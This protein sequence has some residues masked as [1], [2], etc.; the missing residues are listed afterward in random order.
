[1]KLRTVGR[2]T[3]FIFGST[4]VG[5]LASLVTVPLLARY[6]GVGNYGRYTYVYAFVG[7]FEALSVFGV[8]PIFTREV[9]RHRDRAAQYLGNIVPLKLALLG[10]TLVILGAASAVF[11]ERA[12]WLFVAI[13]GS[14]VLI[15]K[16][17]N[18]NIS[19]F[20]AFERMEY[21]FIVNSV[22]RLTALAGVVLAVRL[23]WGL[24][25]VFGA[26]AAG[27]FAAA[28]CGTG[29]AWVRFAKPEFRAIP[30]LKRWFMKSAWPLGVAQE[31][32]LLYNRIGTVLLGQW[33]SP[34]AVGVF[35]GAYR[36]YWFGAVRPAQ[37][38]SQAALPGL[39]TESRDERRF[40]AAF[41]R[42]RW[43]VLAG[44][45]ALAV[46]L[47]IF[48]PWVVSVLLGPEFTPS[49][50]ILRWLC[51]AIPFTF[52]NNL[53]ST[54]LQAMDRQRLDGFLTVGTFVANLGLSLAL[55]PSFGALGAAWAFAAALVLAGVAR[56][57]SFHF[58]ASFPSGE[59]VV[60]GD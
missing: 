13:C 45:A 43:I 27:A 5:M 35:T 58:R 11:V 28:V 19:L 50:Q 25:G 48:S 9:A 4:V 3:L 31:A 32:G 53:Y 23:D 55:V 30:G 7:M 38:I 24:A 51:P 10:L 54:G 47:W 8:H 60:T 46:A 41:R 52:L 1:M 15:R 39:A 29:I 42:M 20:R 40:L 33:H 26:F 34:A 49:V 36:M 12:L 18:L 14:E 56:V 6:L 44:S 2:N 22:D 37:A 59:H 16:F 21:E 57:L 17:F